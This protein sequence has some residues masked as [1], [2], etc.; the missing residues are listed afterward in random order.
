MKK[1]YFIF[2]VLFG[3]ALTACNM[4]HEHTWGEYQYN[5]SEHWRTYTCG[6][7]A[8]NNN[9]N[10][11]DDNVDGNCD[12]CNYKMSEPHTHTWTWHI[13]DIGH[14]QTFT[15]GCPSEE[16][17]SPHFDN[18][19]LEKILLLLLFFLHVHNPTSFDKYDF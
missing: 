1:I 7:T 6:H 3:I 12:V 15:C 10:H 14:I 4:Q 18:D 8:P 13:E 9:S 19:K 17:T 16:G 5:E 2:A 11:I